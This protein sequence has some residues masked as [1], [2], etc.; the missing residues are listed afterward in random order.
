MDLN[1]EQVGEGLPFDGGSNNAGTTKPFANG[2]F[3]AT[4]ISLTEM[5]ITSVATGTVNQTID[6][7]FLQCSDVVGVVVGDEEISIPGK[8]VLETIHVPHEFYG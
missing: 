2:H 8:Y 6:G 4:I 5:A 1:M 7:Y 3:T